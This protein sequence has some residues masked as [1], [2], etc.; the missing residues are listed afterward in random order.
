MRKI[1]LSGILLIVMVLFSSLVLGSLSDSKALS[2]S[3]VNQDPDPASGG[4]T[5]EIRLGVENRGGVQVDDL[6]LEIV[7]SYPFSIVEGDKST[8]DVGAIKAFQYDS[9]MKIVKFKLMVAN[10]VTAGTY[11]FKIK[12]YEK[13]K[14]ETVSE[15]TISVDVENKESAEIV[16]IDQ[17]ELVPGKITPMTF[18]V[19]NVGSSPLRDLTFEWENSDDIILPVGSDNSKYIKFIDVG[20]SAELNF[21]VIASANADPD[22]YKL[23]LKLTYSDST[24]GTE[25]EIDT[26]AGIYVGGATDFDVA[27]SGTSSGQASFSVANIG[28]VSAS[29]VTVSIPQQSGWRVSGSSSA[30]IGN[31][32]E[33][34]YTIASFSLQQTG[35]T[36][37]FQQN[38]SS[39]DTQSAGASGY[40]RTRNQTAGSQA[41]RSSTVKVDII[42]TDSRGN[43]NTIEKEVPI[44]MS[45]GMS[46]S[47]S[48]SGAN[49][50]AGRRQT[51]PVYQQIWTNYKWY[52]IGV[53]LVAA[54]VFVHIRYK[55]G[56]LDDPG[57]TYSKAVKE[58]FKSRKKKQKK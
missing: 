35:G 14:P 56:K 32:N 45:S 30:I 48:Y 54:L 9:D 16:Y 41:S 20:D 8:I 50:F 5:V 1:I 19:N 26:K 18:T 21:N 25:K 17:V 6:V 42:Y 53:L 40:Q 38:P 43:R 55:S 28:S 31:L 52:I 22:L 2:L 34:D 51:Q 36:S 29:S 3:L 44:E 15:Q 11:T 47:T 24:T 10:S 39:T 33:G 37:G 46:N 7:P 58:L 13:A 23:D 57:Y 27:Y 12:A 49:G 4:N